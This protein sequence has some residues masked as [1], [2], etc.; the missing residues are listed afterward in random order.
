MME[1][2]CPYHTVYDTLE[3][4]MPGNLQHH[5][6][7][8]VGISNALT[9]NEEILASWA[10]GESDLSGDAYSIDLL[11]SSMLLLTSASMGVLY[12]FLTIA[13]LTVTLCL[14]CLEPKGTLAALADTGLLALAHFVS[15]VFSILVSFAIS[16]VVT[17]NWGYWYERDGMAIWLYVLPCFAIELLFGR[18]LL[19]RRFHGLSPQQLQ[20]RS[21]CATLVLFVPIAL[22]L[23][24]AGA[25]N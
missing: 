6:D 2:R 15:I 25:P 16:L 13:T 22:A 10:N 23:A 18:V 17:G 9:R 11:S 5:G 14:A 24:L 20:W 4:I 1:D 12:G 21:T 7:N 3:H 19:L 8:F